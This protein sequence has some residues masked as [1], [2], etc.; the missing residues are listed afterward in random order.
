M[1]TITANKENNHCSPTLLCHMTPVLSAFSHFNPISPCSHLSLHPF[2]RRLP[3]FR[4]ADSGFPTHCAIFVD[5]VCTL[6][7]GPTRRNVLLLPGDLETSCQ[8]L[9]QADWWQKEKQSLTH[10]R[11]FLL[12]LYHILL[13]SKIYSMGWF[14]CAA[15]L[16]N[17]SQSCSSFSLLKMSLAKVNRFEYCVTPSAASQLNSD[18]NVKLKKLSLICSN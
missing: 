11:L 13:W 9:I 6:A 3:S 2:L 12:I 8:L 14:T 18:K 1:V 16:I 10:K 15:K 4:C 17:C 7:D 5:D